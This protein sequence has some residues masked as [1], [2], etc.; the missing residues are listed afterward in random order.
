MS[1]TDCYVSLWLPTAS[2]E[3]L[4][5]RTISNCP[6]PEWNESFNFQIQ[7]QVKVRC[8]RLYLPALPTFLVPSL[9]AFPSLCLCVLLMSICLSFYLLLVILSTRLPIHPLLPSVCLVF[10]PLQ[11]HESLYLLSC[12][13]CPS[14]YLIVSRTGYLFSPKRVCFHYLPVHTPNLR[15]HKRVILFTRSKAS[16]IPSRGLSLS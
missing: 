3:R 10:V 4:R 14:T 11:V 12:L 9:P 1:Q 16:L 7:R 8:G 2:H 15:I 5:T 6:N 13:S